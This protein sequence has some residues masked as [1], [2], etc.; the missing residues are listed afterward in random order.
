MKGKEKV[1][2]PGF[3]AVFKQNKVGKL[4]LAIRGSPAP[5]ARCPLSPSFEEGLGGGER[6]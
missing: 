4:C 1:G 5:A 6:C 2:V 3:R